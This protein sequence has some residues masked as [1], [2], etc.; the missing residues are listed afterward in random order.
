MRSALLG[1]VAVPLL[2]AACSAEDG[3]DAASGDEADQT[4][5]ACAPMPACDGA[6]GP[7][8]GAKKSFDHLSSKVTTTLGDA[9]HRGRD[10]I[11]ATGDTQWII[12][13]LAYGPTDKDLEDEEVEVWAERGCGGSWEK[14][15]TARTTEDNQHATVE[16]VEDSGGRVYFQIPAGKELALGRHRV[17]LVVAGD[18]TSADLL[19]DVVP[20]N[21]PVLVSD[22]DGTLTSSELVE[23]PA[24]LVGVQPNAQPDAAKVLSALVAKGY[25]PIYLTA[26]AERLTDR[27]REFLKERGFPPGIVHTTT[28]GLGS[29]G[30]AAAQYKS[31]ELALIVGKGLSIKWAF[32][33]KA[34]DTD[35]YDSVHVDPKNHRIFLGVDDP[36]GGRRIDKYA[37][38]VPEA[39]SAKRVCQ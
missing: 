29:F 5:A 24:G 7:T 3:A 14:L 18:H 30:D 25:H 6:A 26:R 9:N 8:L 35:A 36:H 22:V 17:R 33:N 1:I 34:S 16:G 12:G 31:R 13:K 23:F 37:E 32:G 10:A 2:L 15:G 4:A 19:V 21:A 38:L 28:S 27:T 39:E 20:K 11:Y